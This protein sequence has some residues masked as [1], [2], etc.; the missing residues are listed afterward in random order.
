MSKQ[1]LEELEEVFTELTIFKGIDLNS[2]EILLALRK[3]P[4][5]CNTE[6]FKRTPHDTLAY[7][8]YKLINSTNPTDI[9]LKREIHFQGIILKY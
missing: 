3:E 7:L 9:K 1:D 4:I 8:Y 6:I 5:V 2:G